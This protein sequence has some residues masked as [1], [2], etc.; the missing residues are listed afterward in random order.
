MESKFNWKHH[1]KQHFNLKGLKQELSFVFYFCILTVF[2]L[3]TQS[4]KQ[5]QFIQHLIDEKNW[6][7]MALIFGGIS[8]LA[9]I[10]DTV[11]KIA[12][13]LLKILFSLIIKNK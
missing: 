3:Y 2:I 7:I 11:I 10:L 8:I 4:P 5:Q 6:L 1:F 12:W 9:V 13:L